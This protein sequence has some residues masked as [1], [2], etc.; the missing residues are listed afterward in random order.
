MGLTPQERLT[1]L[2]NIIARTGG[3]DKVDLKAELAKAEAGVNQMNSPMSSNQG[4]T[5]TFSPQEGN[6]STQGETPLNQPGNQPLETPMG[7]GENMV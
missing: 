7:E 4:V 6:M 1:V 2:N 5:G 3:M